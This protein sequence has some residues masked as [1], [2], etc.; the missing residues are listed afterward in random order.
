MVEELYEM[1][2][3]AGLYNFLTAVLEVVD[4]KL[5]TM[6]SSTPDAEIYREVAEAIDSLLP[7]CAELEE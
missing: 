1:L 3:S 4:D 5:D 7:T 6:D 2:E